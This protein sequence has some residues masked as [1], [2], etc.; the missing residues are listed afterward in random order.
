MVGNGQGSQ[1]N[2]SEEYRHQCEVRT[3]LRWRLTE[4]RMKVIDYFAK[5]SI[6]RG[7]EAG[8]RLEDDCRTQWSLGN[9]GQDGQWIEQGV[10]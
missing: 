6:S 7:K 1:V 4:G 9:R 8:D 3:I 2:T 5:V 10:A